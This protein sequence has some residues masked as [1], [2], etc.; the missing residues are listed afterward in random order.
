M[1][2]L[3]NESRKAF[4]ELLDCLRE[5]DERWLG[6]EWNL[7]TEADVAEGFR[8]LMHLLQG[9]L[10]GHFEDDPDHPRFRRIVSPTR[11][12]MGD[13]PDAIYY[14]APVNPARVYRI[15]GRMDGAVYVSLT[16]EAGA[17]EGRFASNTAGVLNDAQFD[18]AA[19]GSFELIAGGEPRPHNWLALPAGASRITTRH[20]YE[21]ERTPAADPKHHLALEIEPLPRMAPAPFMDDAGVAA[22]IRRVA[23]FLRGRSL[24]QQPMAR[25]E[26]P[27]FVSIVPNQFPPPV[28]PGD[29]AFAAADA[30]YSMA[31]Y[32]LGPDQALVV[33]GRWP[34]C[35][36]ANVSLWNRHMQTYDYATR[37]VSRNRKQTRLD[38]DGSFRMVLAHDD[39]GVPNWIDTEKRPFGLVFWRFMLPEGPI[40]TPRAEVVPFAEIARN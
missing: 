11:K 7:T 38:A 10:V 32:V 34:R 16:V 29:F 19:D 37:Q 6:P 9:G 12:F 39:P 1:A 18:V 21:E 40:E 3:L 20:Y 17:Q 24:E 5:I 25:R 22:G 28:K 27:A 15:R 14:D 23:N 30:A 2:A 33:E 35:R 36:C 13:N 31:P 8:N 4:H 26:Q